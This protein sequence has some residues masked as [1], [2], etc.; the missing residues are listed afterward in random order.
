M[1]ANTHSNSRTRSTG[2]V[3]FKWFVGDARENCRRKDSCCWQPTGQMQELKTIDGFPGRYCKA[4]GDTD[5]D[6]LVV[7]TISDGVLTW[8]LDHG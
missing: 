6:R 4:C 5:G 1:Q 8:N 3:V 2:Q 7:Y